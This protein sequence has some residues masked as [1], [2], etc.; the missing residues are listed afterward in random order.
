MIYIENDG[1]IA[2]KTTTPKYLH[3][4]NFDQIVNAV[5]SNLW[6]IEIN[7][8]LLKLKF[9]KIILAKM[10]KAHKVN[11]NFNFKYSISSTEFHRLHFIG[12]NA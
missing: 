8:H 9:P 3:I 10:Q 6:R 12:L 4:L 7:A 11:F 2:N 1:M 5:K